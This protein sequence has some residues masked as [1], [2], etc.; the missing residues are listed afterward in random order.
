MKDILEKEIS[1]FRKISVDHL[2]ALLPKEGSSE[3]EVLDS[4]S[5]AIFSSGPDKTG[6]WYLIGRPL[7]PESGCRSNYPKRLNKIVT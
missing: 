4:F 6:I 3:L 1:S 5:Y 2:R 7:R